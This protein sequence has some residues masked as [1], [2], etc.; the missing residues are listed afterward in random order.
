MIEE[1]CM[2]NGFHQGCCMGPALFNLYTCL[3]VERRLE[4]VRSDEGAG[5]TIQYKLD[6]KLLRRYSKNTSEKRV[7]ECQFADNGAILSLTRPH[8]REGSIGVPE[9]QP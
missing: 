9:N 4:K 2:Q 1:I 8:S 5:M 7:T 3:A 6:R